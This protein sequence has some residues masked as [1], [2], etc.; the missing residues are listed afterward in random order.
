M[1][2]I[3]CLLP[4]GYLDTDGALHHEAELTPLS[5]REEELLA[6][7]A[8]RSNAAL[9]TR[10]LSRCVL[11]IGTISPVS[12]ALA[13]ALLV[14][15]RQYLMLVLRGATFGEQV[16]ATVV[17]PW[18]GCARK[19]DIDFAL[20]DIPVRRATRR[21]TTYAM[22]LSDDAA[23]VDENGAA[24][25]DV[26]FR[27]PTG[28]DQELIAPLALQ[29]E[30]RALAALL[31]L[32][33]CAIGDLRQPSE[34]LISQLCPLARAEIERAM[35]SVAPAVELTI[36]GQCPECGRMF[37]RP[38]DIQDFVFDELRIGRAPLYREVHYLAYHYHWSEREIM[39]LPRTKRRMYIEI[40]ADEIE[41]IHDALA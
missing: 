20:G 13:R 4:G 39:S 31:S 29:S 33:T 15:D 12:E 36:S 37:D 18:A 26:V 14:A 11:R 16:Q 41:R 2:T 6:S 21:S 32:C 8:G 17:C 25:R 28:G 22:Q 35:E 3:T 24:H 10:I 23:F 7:R 40:L 9:V 38:L 30:Q 34:M 27:L 19:V 5:G 1:D